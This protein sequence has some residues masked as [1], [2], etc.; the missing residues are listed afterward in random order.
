MEYVVRILQVSP[1]RG[2]QQLSSITNSSSPLR[3]TTIV[4]EVK[5]FADRR[6]PITAF[7]TTTNS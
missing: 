4:L 6:Q 1:Q 3:S 7:A 2:H 5:D